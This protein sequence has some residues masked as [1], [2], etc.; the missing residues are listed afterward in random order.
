MIDIKKVLKYSKELSTLYIHAPGDTSSEEFLSVYFKILH[1]SLEATDGLQAYNERKSS[2][3][4]YFDI[5]LVDSIL[6]VQLCYDILAINPE[7]KIIISLENDDTANLSDFFKAGI[8]RFIVKPL[9][10]HSLNS[11]F[12]D[13]SKDIHIYHLLL[14]YKSVHK[15]LKSE[16]ELL[17]ARFSSKVSSLKAS[18]AN[19]SDFLASMS[20][21]LRSPMNAIIGFSDLLIDE[22]IEDEHELDYISKISRSSKML[23]GLINDILDFSKIEAGK[24]KLESIAF[25]LNMILD[26]AADVIGQ[27]AQEK[28]LDLVF[29]VE[30]AVGAEYIGDPLRLSQI[31]INLLTNAVKFTKEGSV[32]LKVRALDR[33]DGKSDI[34]FEVIDTGIGLSPE[35]ITH[36]FEKYT[37]AESSTTREY[38]GTGLG[39]NISKQL[40][41]LMNGRI[42]V[43]SEEGE[44]STFFVMVKLNLKDPNNYRNYRL[45]SKSLMTKRMLIVDEHQKSAQA[46]KNMLQYFHMPV[47]LVHKAS[48]AAMLLDRETFDVVFIDERSYSLLESRHLLKSDRPKVA[49]LSERMSELGI[50]DEHVDV[51]LKKPFN[52]QMVFDAI[53]KLYGEKE[54]S[55]ENISKEYKKEDLRALGRQN[56]L[57]AEDNKI[58]QRLVQGLFDQIEFDLTLVNNGAEAVEM[59]KN[60]KNFDM[61]LMDIH[62]PVMDGYGATKAIRED[63]SLDDIPIIALTADAMSEDIKKAKECGMQEHI[64]KPI[65]VRAL[66][67]IL[68]L[69]LKPK[70]REFEDKLLIE[71]DKSKCQ[72]SCL[73]QESKLPALDYKGALARMGGNK[74]LYRSLVYEFVSLYKDSTNKIKDFMQSEEHSTGQEYC[75]N[76]KDAAANIGVKDLYLHAKNLENIFKLKQDPLF[77]DQLKQY[78]NSLQVFVDHIERLI[79]TSDE[80]YQIESRDEMIIVLSQLLHSVKNKRVTECLSLVDE[81]HKKHWPKEYAKTIFEIISSIRLYRFKEALATLESIDVIK[82]S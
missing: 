63:K 37:Q 52:Q 51:D 18:I 70:S 5:V 61:V 4:H 13:I 53:L 45:P 11:V 28:S 65:D 26:H 12:Y 16:K 49:L 9:S 15:K 42:W 59:L 58:N 44:G 10:F 38:G 40:I 17:E 22:G 57:L 64:A 32:S 43:E 27:L 78:E 36:L 1:I 7:Q 19:K 66:Y 48:E 30:H 41:E 23:L 67:G 34:Q 71:E 55:I 3:G 47:S 29:D 6:G 35:G 25:D 75:H 39:L 46:L 76:I 60:N 69:F 14:R 80:E 2:R 81:L 82:T 68:M 24:L 62:M 74:L 50:T 77:S 79:N 73:E 8:N 54:I 33:N 56:I 21:E 31:I 72:E 20:H